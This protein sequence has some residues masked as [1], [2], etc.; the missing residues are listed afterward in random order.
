MREHKYRAWFQTR[1]DTTQKYSGMY[2]VVALDFINRFV[3]VD[4]ASIFCQLVFSFD[5]I[6]LLEFIGFLDKNNREVYEG[7][8]VTC[9]EIW[10]NKAEGC[11]LETNIV[12]GVVKLNH[13]Q[14][15]LDATIYNNL[16]EVVNK[17][18]LHFPDY[19]EGYSW[20]NGIWILDDNSQ[21]DTRYTDL[22]VIGSELGTPELLGSVQSQVLPKAILSDESKA[23]GQALR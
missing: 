11:I 1:E 19:R 13:F 4:R 17:K 15:S 12:K 16:A 21:I 10:V 2:D 8:I 22:E 14:W 18:W 7:D 9:T 5:D 6:E 3:Q 20:G 23:C